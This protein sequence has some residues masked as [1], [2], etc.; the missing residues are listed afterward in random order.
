MIEVDFGPKK[1]PI[2]LHGTSPFMG[3]GQFGLKGQEW[4]QRFFHHPKRMGELFALF[5]E[6]GFPGVHVVGYPTIIEAVRLTKKSYPLKI[7]VSLLPDNWEDNLEE[8]ADLEPDV[9]FVHGIM[10]DKYLRKYAGELLSCFQAIR[11]LDAFPGLATHDS[12]QTL[13]ALQTSSN[14]LLEES[15]GLLIPINSM[16]WGMGGSL[17]D[18][19]K[20]LQKLDIYPVMAMKTLAA[21]QLSPKEA[22]E[23]IFKIPQVR[24]AAVGMTNKEEVAEIAAIG[25]S[26][27]E[28]TFLE[29]IS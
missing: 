1:L 22:L 25:Q 23:F 2:L 14:P 26:I 5:C 3:A 24:I 29:K 15:F 27:L 11:D 13:L 20:L 17:N 18:I 7:A 16:G 19:I 12:Y 28:T 6:K 9:V 4:Y 10:T 8:V 21:G